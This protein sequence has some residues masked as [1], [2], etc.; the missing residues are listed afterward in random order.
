M[1][2]HILKWC[3][4]LQEDRIARFLRSFFPNNK[5]TRK[6]KKGA[7]GIPPKRQWTSYSCTASVAQMVAH[8][9]GIRIGHRKAIEMTQC[10]P[11]GATLAAVA[12]ALRLSHRLRPRTLRSKAQI[13][14]AL[15]QGQ[16]VMTN[17]D[18][19]YIS[20]HAILLVGETPKG[21]WIADPAIGKV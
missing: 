16:P 15:R 14:A 9:Y 4:S 21:F 13:K 18:L 8:Y 6:R 11:D 2:Q 20:D 7:L 3:A 19:N 12:Q 10:K 5:R 1:I 17:D